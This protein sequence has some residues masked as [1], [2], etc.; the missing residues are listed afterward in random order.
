VEKGD[1]LKKDKQLHYL[2]R[3]KYNIKSQNKIKEDLTALDKLNG[4]AYLL[5]YIPLVGFSIAIMRSN[6]DI[7]EK[8]II[9]SVLSL[10]V[11]IFIQ[12]GTTLKEKSRNTVEQSVKSEL[13]L[14]MLNLQLLS[15]NKNLDEE[16][17]ENYKE[18]LDLISK[19]K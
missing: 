4:F 10:F 15:S 8:A 6:M 2:Q 1:I 3:L 18:V 12:V 5:F 16:L 19:E 13:Y 14:Y 7:A 17:Q 9:I 11:T